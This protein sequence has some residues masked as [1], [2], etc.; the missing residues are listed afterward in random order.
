MRGKV[1]HSRRT[2]RSNLQKKLPLK[3][4]SCGCVQC[5]RLQQ[6]RIFSRLFSLSRSISFNLCVCSCF[7]AFDLRNNAKPHSLHSTR[8]HLYLECKFQLLRA[9]VSDFLPQSIASIY[10]NRFVSLCRPLL[11]LGILC[12]CSFVCATVQRCRCDWATAYIEIWQ[13]Q[14][15][16][17][18]ML[19]NC[20]TMWCLYNSFIC[21]YAIRAHI[22]FHLIRTIL[23]S[24]ELLI[25]NVYT[26]NA[27]II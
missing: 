27:F 18:S 10:C 17:R 13:I 26:R 4:S 15:Q 19:S 6:R 5:F 20:G 14:I 21:A 25:L 23:L 7:S 12:I 8:K 22:I 2:I 1:N 3:K 9:A 16:I 11:H 24:T